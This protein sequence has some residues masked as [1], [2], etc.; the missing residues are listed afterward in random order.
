MLGRRFAFTAVGGPSTRRRG[1][2]TNDEGDP[3]VGTGGLLE[4]RPNFRLDIFP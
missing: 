3:I 2:E 4:Q 1:A